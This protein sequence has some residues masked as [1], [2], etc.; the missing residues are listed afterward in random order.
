MK[1][2][3][4]PHTGTTL[5][6]LRR[7]V[8]LQRLHHLDVRD[9][10]HL[11]FAGVAHAS[12]YPETD[13]IRGGRRPSGPALGSRRSPAARVFTLW[14]SIP[15]AVRALPAP[16]LLRVGLPRGESERAVWGL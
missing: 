14:A 4:L 3:P 16:T 6:L 7:T 15:D 11:L 13:P 5:G 1:S 8:Q 9:P 2:T 10:L 12:A